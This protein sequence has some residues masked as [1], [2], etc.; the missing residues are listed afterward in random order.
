MDK[1]LKTIQRYTNRVNE[2]EHQLDRIDAN[3]KKETLAREELIRKEALDLTNNAPIEQSRKVKRSHDVLLK[4]EREKKDTQDKITTL[5]DTLAVLGTE[6][7]KTVYGRLHSGFRDNINRCDA[8]NKDIGQLKF[9]V[10]QKERELQDSIAE[11]SRA[12]GNQSTF[13]KQW[14]IDRLIRCIQ[15]PGAQEFRSGVTAEIIHAIG[16]DIYSD[17]SEAKAEQHRAAKK[18]SEKAR[19]VREQELA[20]VKHYKQQAM[21]IIQGRRDM[22]KELSITHNRLSLPWNVLMNFLRR[23]DEQRSTS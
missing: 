18:Q 12:Q 6:Y 7:F 1:Q 14:D 16:E 20:K 22:P 15:N 3:I 2:L 23:K 5:K 21:D 9:Q 13:K 4:L 19:K 10:Q 17:W 8:L 11:K